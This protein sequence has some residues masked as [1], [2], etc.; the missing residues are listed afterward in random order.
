[1]VYGAELRPECPSD[2]SNVLVADKIY[3]NIFYHCQSGRG[4][5]YMCREGTVFDS[6]NQESVGSCRSEELVNCDNRLILT[7]QGKRS[8]KVTNKKL[9]LGKHL[10]AKYSNFILLPPVQN[11]K[12]IINVPFD[13]KGRIDGHWR[14]VRYCDVFHACLAGEQKRS[15]GCNQIGERFYFDDATQKY[16]KKTENDYLIKKICCLDVNFLLEI[17]MVVNQINIIHLLNQYRRY[18]V[19]N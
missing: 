7:T 18:P 9:P 1:M 17:R 13:C 3:C 6:L 4:S 11:Q 19:H 14:D 12:E 5:V 10:Q 16:R 2:V 15:Y 8:A